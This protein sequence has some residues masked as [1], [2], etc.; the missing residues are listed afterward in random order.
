MNFRDGSRLISLV[1]ELNQLFSFCLLSKFA[2]LVDI[3]VTQHPFETRVLT[4]GSYLS[5]SPYDLPQGE[6]SVF[7]MC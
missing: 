1:Y 7:R 6:L 4:F 3:A 2:G 5:H